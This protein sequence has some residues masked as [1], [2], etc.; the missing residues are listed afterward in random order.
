MTGPVPPSAGRTLL[1]VPARY[2]STRFPGKPL[3]PIGGRSMLERTA[4]IAARAA[5]HVGNA[6]LV[7]A[8]DDERIAEHAR[9]LGH[10]AVITPEAIAS[11]TDRALAAVEALGTAPDVVVNLQ[12]D[13]PFTPVA[14]VVA[15]IG[16]ARAMPGGVATPVRP[17]TWEA[18]DALRAH[19]EA[20]PFSGTTCVR[21][22]DG[23]ALWFSKSL[24][25][26]IR[27]EAALRAAGPLSPVLRHV[28]LYAYRLEALRA[29]AAA[30][31]SH[32]EVLEGLEQLRFLELGIPVHTL[33][34][35]EPAIAMSGI[36]TPEDLALAERL[37]AEH[38]EP[39]ERLA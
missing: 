32:Y 27:R 16:T 2:G 3:A 8:T 10:E 7:V 21:A 25:P 31:P 26:A 15:L 12:G 38:G 37:L 6:D 29:F 35:D 9:A 36:D 20:A 22:P 1:V 19:K 23:R 5:A 17:M 18:L 14:T 33:E 4:G 30:P 28:G 34:V 13:A 39:E 11:G 24:I